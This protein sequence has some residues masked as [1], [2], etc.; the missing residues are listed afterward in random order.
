MKNLN[1][2]INE[3]KYKNV[4]YYDE[5]TN[6]WLKTKVVFPC[7]SAFYID[8]EHKGESETMYSITGNRNNI[9]RAYFQTIDEVKE[10][11]NEYIKLNP[12]QQCVIVKQ[13]KEDEGKIVMFI[14]SKGKEID[15][16]EDK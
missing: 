4:R 9:G 5:K 3:A 1:N 7:F 13:L 2:Y 11:V 15:L 8:I 14:N 16:N 6:K 12:K 10:A